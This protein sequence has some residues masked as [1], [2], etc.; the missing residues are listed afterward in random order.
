MR[1]FL[2]S[3][4]RCAPRARSLGIA[5][6]LA[7]CSLSPSPEGAL[8]NGKFTYVCP[9]SG[10][11]AWCPGDGTVPASIAVGAGFSVTYT[12]QPSGSSQEGVTAFSVVP[13]SPALATGSDATMVAQAPGMLALLAEAGAGTSV[14]DFFFVQIEPIASL[15]SPTD[16]AVNVGQS[17]T[18]SVKPLDA[19]GSALAGDVACTWTVTTG[20]TF[21]SLGPDTSHRAVQVKDVCTAG[22][23]D[24]SVARVGDRREDRAGWTR[25]AAPR[26]GRGAGDPLRLLGDRPC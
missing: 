2:S 18:L 1:A 14:G 20:A 4:C 5:L 21:V 9:T 11:D 16:V 8:A 26:H 10:F 3:V 13:A 7:A 12:P 22:T 6:T 15:M 19:K 25:D 17:T 24:V 23:A